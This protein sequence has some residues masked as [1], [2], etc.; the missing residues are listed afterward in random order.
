MSG[1]CESYTG[2]FGAAFAG[3]TAFLCGA[4][5]LA[6]TKI[7]QVAF[8]FLFVTCLGP[9]GDISIWYLEILWLK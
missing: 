9:L 5:Q 1:V 2:R 4:E 6:E 7:W 3:T 8:H